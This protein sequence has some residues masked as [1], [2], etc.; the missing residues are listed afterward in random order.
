[1]S[2][3]A[4]TG[5]VPQYDPPLSVAGSDGDVPAPEYGDSYGAIDNEENGVGTHAKVTGLHCDICH[6]KT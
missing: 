6:M 1:M 3:N 2:S 5:Q 4:A